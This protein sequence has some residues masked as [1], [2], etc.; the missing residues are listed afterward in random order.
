VVLAVAFSEA[1]LPVTALLAFTELV[2]LRQRR[3]VFSAKELARQI[4][5]AFRAQAEQETLLAVSVST[6]LPEQG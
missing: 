2:R 1:A 4:L 3:L 5:T 6:A